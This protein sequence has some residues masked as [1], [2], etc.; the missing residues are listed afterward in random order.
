MSRSLLDLEVDW[1]RRVVV[2][3]RSSGNIE[4]EFQRKCAI[5]RRVVNHC[6]DI[7]LKRLFSWSNLNSLVFVA[8]GSAVNI[9]Q[10]LGKVQCKKRSKN[11]I[12]PK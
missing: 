1:A 11:A 9:V 10:N 7:P 6:K 5:P 2:F 4:K 12:C 3:R 8:S